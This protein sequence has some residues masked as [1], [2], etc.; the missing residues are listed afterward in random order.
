[1]DKVVSFEHE[2]DVRGVSSFLK[3]DN[4]NDR[5]D[6][7]L[8]S[9]SDQLALIRGGNQAQTVKVDILKG[10][11]E[12]LSCIILITYHGRDDLILRE[13]ETLKLFANLIIS[14]TEIQEERPLS[15]KLVN[16]LP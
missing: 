9:L 15:T 16:H 10:E 4:E 6:F 14:A 3:L 8:H 5:N 13:D 11:R 12:V 1:M 7:L 2:L